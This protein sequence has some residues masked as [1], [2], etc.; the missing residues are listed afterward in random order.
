MPPTCFPWGGFD[1]GGD[2]L[3]AHFGLFRLRTQSSTLDSFS[4]GGRL[5]APRAGEWE[6]GLLL[7][8]H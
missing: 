5:C 4:L 3:D 6:T 7:G 1:L 2:E 8:S